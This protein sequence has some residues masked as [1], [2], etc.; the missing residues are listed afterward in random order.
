MNYELTA[1]RILIKEF[2]KI[3]KAIPFNVLTQDN[4]ETVLGLAIKEKDIKKAL[5]K[6]H[7][8]IGMDAGKTELRRIAELEKSVKR[9]KRNTYPLF[10]EAFQL[11]LNDYFNT[12]G[13]S[14]ITLL[15]ET[16][17]A[18]VVSEMKKS[19]PDAETIYEV[20]DRIYKAVNS[21]NFYK[22]QAMRIARTETTMAVNAATE[23]G[24]TFSVFVMEKKWITRMDG[25][26]RQSHLEANGDRVALNGV[27]EVGGEKMKYPGD[28]TNGA[29]ATNIVNCRCRFSNVPKTNPDGSWVMNI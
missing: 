9:I 18:S 7:Y 23:I 1:F 14:H 4:A 27:F 25:K 16:Y 10:S 8:T 6:V 5:Y 19:T 3:G 20:R 24:G 15:T 13:G 2:R 29:T 11:F 26:E 12:Y 22:W 21:P 17:I 28:R